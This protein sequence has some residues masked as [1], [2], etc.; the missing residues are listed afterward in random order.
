MAMATESPV[1]MQ[2]LALRDA[3]AR[4]ELWKTFHAMAAV[5]DKI[6]WEVAEKQGIHDR[7]TEHGRV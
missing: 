4:A 6:G 3:L 1:I 5:I 2:A 7:E